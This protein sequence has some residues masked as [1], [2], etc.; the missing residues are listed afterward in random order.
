MRCS[1]GGNI[2]FWC[3][4][5]EYQLGLPVCVPLMEPPQKRSR[6]AVDAVWD[7]YWSVVEMKEESRR[8]VAKAASVHVAL[9]HSAWEE[10]EGVCQVLDG[11]DMR[12]TAVL[13][14]LQSLT[15]AEL[16]ASTHTAAA[17]LR[18][19]YGGAATLLG[20]AK[21]NIGFLV[22]GIPMRP[23]YPAIQETEE[24][25]LGHYR[26]MERFARCTA[27]MDR[28]SV[29]HTG[30]R[31]DCVV[32]E[33][34]R[35]VEGVSDAL[36]HELECGCQLNVSAWRMKAVLRTKMQKLDACIDRCARAT[37]ELDHALDIASGTQ[38]VPKLPLHQCYICMCYHMF[39]LTTCSMCWGAVCGGCV[40]QL[41]RHCLDCGGVSESTTGEVTHYT[42]Q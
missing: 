1:G 6:K 41:V 16:L 8:L 24:E 33:L 32:G 18:G 30:L 31:G 28:F 40:Q 26:R 7:K 3:A 38:M 5:T 21:D 13:K 36:S 10:I 22:E 4:H 9:T 23:S 34:R 35:R 29:L 15:L 11:L 14:R 19:E 39:G 25:L 12:R 17:N 20:F 27:A 2:L 37:A 42:Y